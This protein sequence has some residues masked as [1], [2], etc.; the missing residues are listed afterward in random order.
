LIVVLLIAATVTS[1][2]PKADPC[3]GS[4]TPEVNACLAAE[5]D[6]SRARL[7]RYVEAALDRYGEDKDAA[8]RLGIQASQ[9]AFEAYRS[10]ECQTV[11]ED[12]KDG[13]IRGAMSLS[14]EIRLTDERTHDVW[15]HWLHY[16]DSTPPILPEPK[17]TK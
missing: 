16:M 2:A 3:K 7:N 8:V 6:Q 5:L 13:T 17:A 12:W 15:Q 10:I 9:H 4:T 11:Y 1:A 14:C